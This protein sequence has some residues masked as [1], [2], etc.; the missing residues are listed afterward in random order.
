LFGLN[1]KKII[2]NKDI[3]YNEM[4]PSDIND[5]K[6]AACLKCIYPKK[7]LKFSVIFKISDKNKPPVIQF[8]F[9]DGECGIF[10]KTIIKLKKQLRKSMMK[11]PNINSDSD[12]DEK[13]GFWESVAEKVSHAIGNFT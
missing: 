3:H 7:E 6:I 11:K 8:N 4:N 13:E 12:S 1:L 9:K 2:E 5:Q 10:R